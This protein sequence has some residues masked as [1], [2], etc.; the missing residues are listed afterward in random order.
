M[1]SFIIPAYNAENTIET[2]INSIL[3]QYPDA[4][5]IVAENGSTD[6]TAQRVEAMIENHSQIRLLHTA[7]GVSAARNAGIQAASGE[8]ITFVDADD[9]WIGKKNEVDALLNTSSVDFIVCSYQKGADAVTH[10]YQCMDMPIE[11]SAI[12]DAKAW[13][14]SKPTLRMISCAK[15]FRR[16]FL[17][18]YN[19]LF[20]TDLRVSEDADFMIRVINST[21]SFLITKK[22]TLRICF[23]TSSVTRSIDPTRIEA[24]LKSLHVMQ[25]E[26]E[27]QSE[28]MKKACRNFVL[29]HLNLIAVHDVFDCDLK[30][31]WRTRIVQIKKVLSD[32]YI[33]KAVLQVHVYDLSDIQLFPAYLFK[34]KLFSLGGFMCLLRSMQNKRKYKE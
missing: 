5:I 8:W 12:D 4:E 33:K 2:A 3:D 27:M 29:A 16:E 28:P 18:E 30:W 24:Y 15:L 17:S 32:E 13:L 21:N 22:Q 9:L 10:C 7:K 26:L 6:Q 23:N 1:L 34:L 25:S 20:N 19:L 31:N 14:I 11:G